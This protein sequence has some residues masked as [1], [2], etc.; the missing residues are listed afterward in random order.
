MV[1]RRIHFAD[2][3]LP[4]RD[5][6]HELGA[7]VGEILRD[8]GGE[9]LFEKVEQARVAA[10]ERRQ[11]EALD[12]EGVEPG[13]GGEALDRAMA[14]MAPREA[15]LLVRAF[16][17]YFLVVNLA[18]QIHRIRRRRDYLRDENPQAGSW[19]DTFER[20]KEGGVG[21]EQVRQLLEIVAQ[22]GR[23]G[24][25]LGIGLCRHTAHRVE[26]DVQRAHQG[27]PG[28]VV[29]PADHVFLGK[30][31]VAAPNALVSREREG[32]R[33][34]CLGGLQVAQAE[35]E[36]GHRAVHLAGLWV[37]TDRLLEGGKRLVRA[38]LRFQD[39]A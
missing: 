9:A 13:A 11:R 5:D 32:G 17:T 4:L 39:G 20:L 3:D 25:D 36:L 2:K 1:L 24:R 35:T 26:D 22:L 30:P 23:R 8:Q 14:G 38:P 37:Q 33:E 21:T 7:L 15:E 31:Q 19:I 29:V 27:L 18:E 10:I 34:V 6:V 16:T 28:R 12:A